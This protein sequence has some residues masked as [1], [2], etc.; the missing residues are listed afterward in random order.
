MAVRIEGSYLGN[1]KV[2]LTHAPSGSEIVTAAPVDNHGDGSSFSPTDLCAA[3]LGTC[4]LTTMGI[5]AQDHGIP[6]GEANFSLEKHMRGDPRRIDR[7][8]VTIHMPAGLT[9][10]Q[11]AR[12]ERV[13]LTCPVARSLLP[14]IEQAVRF[15]YPDG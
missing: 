11:R 7:L 14:A 6:F 13:A 5:H 2:R 8:P 3:A 10:Q 9:A 15:V 1:L 4:M 12:L